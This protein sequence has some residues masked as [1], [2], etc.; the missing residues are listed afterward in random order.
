[1]FLCNI[2][3]PGGLIPVSGEHDLTND[4]LETGRCINA[5]S[6]SAF[7]SPGRYSIRVDLRSAS[8]FSLSGLLA[9]IQDQATTLLGGHPKTETPGTGQSVG[10]ER[11]QEKA[12]TGLQSGRTGTSADARLEGWSVD[13]AD[14]FQSADDGPIMVQP[15]RKGIGLEAGDDFR[16]TAAIGGAAVEK[17]IDKEV[18]PDLDLDSGNYTLLESVGQ[19]AS[20]TEP[21]SEAG[22]LTKGGFVQQRVAGI[23]GLAGPPVQSTGVEPSGRSGFSGVGRPSNTSLQPEQRVKTSERLSEL[24]GLEKAEKTLTEGGF[25]AGRRGEA[26]SAVGVQAPGWSERLANATALG[27]Q[28]LNM[29]GA[30]AVPLVLNGTATLGRTDAGETI[31]FCHFPLKERP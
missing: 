28:G 6:R 12:A 29:T 27:K 21:A 17:V 5:Q 19:S 18:A 23:V 1:L 15:Q 2:S 8:L 11:K 9:N 3:A 26:G 13:E 4:E 7:E 24:G 14:T 30:E 31:Y 25:V 10:V 20:T 16:S 22:K